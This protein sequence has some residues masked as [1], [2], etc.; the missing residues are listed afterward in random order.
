MKKIA[1]ALTI[2]LISIHGSLLAQGMTIPKDSIDSYLC[3]TWEMDYSILGGGMILGRL[4]QAPVVIY[5]FKKD[6]T[7]A[8]L[9]NK[10]VVIQKGTWL[11]DPKKKVINIKNGSG[12]ILYTIVSLTTN[13]LIILVN[14]KET[15]PDDPMEMK[16]VFKIKESK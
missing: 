5:E 14:T 10:G 15:T 11:Y 4:P 12:T 2:A 6:K 8:S 9:D 7:F 13:Q 1:V 3:K 16:L